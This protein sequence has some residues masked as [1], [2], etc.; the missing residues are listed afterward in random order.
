MWTFSLEKTLND[1]RFAYKVVQSK[2][3]L[4]SYLMHYFR[5]KS[6]IVKSFFQRKRQHENGFLFITDFT[7]IWK[8][9]ENKRYNSIFTSV[10]AN[11]IVQNFKKKTNMFISLYF[12]P[13]TATAVSKGQCALPVT[14]A[15]LSMYNTYTKRFRVVCWSEYCSS[16]H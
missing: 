10:F 7:V 4:L 3:K 14:N 9:A 12:K 6:E 11:K 1:F 16:V 15:P 2:A 5:C 13:V 8:K